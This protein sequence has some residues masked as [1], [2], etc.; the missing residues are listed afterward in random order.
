MTNKKVLGISI[1]AVVILIVA[2]IATS[3]AMFT[4][5]LTGT[6]ENKLTTGSVKMNCEE[7]TFSLSNTQ[8]MTDAEGIA[9]T[10]NIATCTLT[11]E[12]VGSMY[13][14]YDIALYDVDSTTPNDSLS[15]NNVKIRAYKTVNG[16]T[17]D[18]AG[19]T[20]SAGVLVSSLKSKAGLHDT[21][22]NSYVIDSDYVKDNKTI[23]YTIKSW[24]ASTGTS[25]TESSTS[26]GECSSSAYSSQAT[27]EEA[28]EIWGSS[29][30]QNQ[31]G[32]SFTFKLKVGATQIYKVPST[33][34][35]NY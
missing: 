11:S 29:K 6:K 7:T 33:P 15:E 18:L 32:G 17:K 30:A 35:Q 14:G 20:S 5:E 12:M 3:Y 13:V 4:A 19:T 8:P 22:I 2:L 1:A 10:N 31:K 26:T 24:V 21:S 34:S 28:G 27:C 16:T 23:V 25:A 9:A